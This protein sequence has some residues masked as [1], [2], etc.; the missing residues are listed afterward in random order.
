MENLT[1][2]WDIDN[3]KL[4]SVRNIR[5]PKLEI[6]FE[7]D[8]AYPDIWIY[9][10]EEYNFDAVS[11]V[12]DRTKY[13]TVYFARKFFH[14]VEDFS[15]LAIQLASQRV[16]LFNFYD[17]VLFFLRKMLIVKNSPG[18]ITA[19][20]SLIE[21][22]ETDNERI[23]I[24]EHSNSVSEMSSRIATMLDISD[25]DIKIA[26]LIHD[27]G[28]I[29]IPASLL[30]SDKIFDDQKVKIF[31]LHSLWGEV[32]YEKL[33]TEKHPIFYESVGFHHE[34]INGQGYFR[35]ISKN[36]PLIAKIV[37]V[38]DVY[39][40]LTKDRPYKL[41]FDKDVAITYIT[42]KSGELFDPEVVN[43]FRQSL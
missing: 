35:G 8:F 33:T 27:I 43:A 18:F 2:N 6:S 1:V 36:I 29:C 7:R 26:G 32:L 28:K 13:F 12:K 37:A 17:D 3:K 39:T 9:E 21:G 5:L 38:S 25:S 11:R 31:Q 20:K 16:I 40:T 34:R 23:V 4:I 24:S 14:N 42:A 19:V 22:A 15:F 30:F 41:Y 10:S